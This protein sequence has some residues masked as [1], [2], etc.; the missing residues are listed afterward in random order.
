M[1]EIS[2]QFGNQLNGYNKTEVNLF[3]KSI[4]EKLQ[5]RAAA[6]DA[7]QQQV[8]GLEAQIVA[9][10]TPEA[11]E[12]PEQIEL[13]DKLM[14]K[15]DGDYQNLLAP[16]IAK[17]KAIEA[18]AEHDYEIRMDQARAAAEGIYAQTADRI[19]VV[20]D[21]NMD[22]LYQ[23]LNEFIYS[24]SLAGRISAFVKACAA[25]SEK[26]AAGLVAASKMPGKAYN[27]VSVKVQEKVEKVKTAIDTY[28]Q[29]KLGA[30]EFVVEDETEA[31]A[32]ELFAEEEL[33]AEA[34]AE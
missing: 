13:Y 9:L 14:K 32:E 17:A 34:V 29:K 22:R 19:A 24:K 5:E 33:V 15:M 6:I 11:V 8:A 18:Q 23:L 26:V 2:T 28:K 12:A 7:L 10:S 31:V 25:V 21:Q 16:A 27:A 4:E 20:V 30:E 3:L 1:S